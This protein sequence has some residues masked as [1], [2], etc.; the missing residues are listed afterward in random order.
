M[1]TKHLLFLLSASVLAA[2]ACGGDFDPYN[3]VKTLRVLGIRSEPPTP[4]QGETATLSALV[5]TTAPD[6]TL[7]YAW[8]W[9]PV[10]GPANTGYPCMVTPEQLAMLSAQAGA[11]LPPLDLGTAPTASFTQ[12]I[13]PQLLAALCAGPEKL[14]CKVGFP[15]QVKL[16]VKTATD[17]V[18]AVWTL[19]LRIDPAAAPNTNPHIDGLNAEQMNAEKMKVLHPIG[20]QPEVVLPRD[21]ETVIHALVPPEVSEPFVTKNMQGQDEPA[22]EALNLSWFVESGNVNAGITGYRA[23]LTNLDDALK[24]K[25]VPGRSEDYAPDSARLFVVIRDNRGGV[26]WTSGAIKL[27][28]TP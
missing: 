20:L 13:N 6:P 10:P 11:P 25:W 14:D 12:S 3:R 22:R 23:N 8:S 16:T 1:R 7:T 18:T 5:Y 4:A 9:C 15:V 2:S 21:E 17:Q 19:R 27:E 26:G 28:A 24:N